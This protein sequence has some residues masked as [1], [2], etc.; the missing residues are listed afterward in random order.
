MAHFARLDENNVVIAVHVV[1]NN[2]LAAGSEIDI[3]DG[4]VYEKQVLSE[5]VGIAFLQGLHGADTRWA[6]TSYNGNF[7]GKYAGIGDV[8][9]ADA[10]EFFSPVVAASP[11]PAIVAPVIETQQAVVLETPEVAPASIESQ[12]TVVLD[13]ADIASLTTEQISG[14]E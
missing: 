14:L 8:Y 11:E 3:V 10:G 7:R 2:E 4:V 9:D 12:Q 13:T 5:T 1:H 6:Q